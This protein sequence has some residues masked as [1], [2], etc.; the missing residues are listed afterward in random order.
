MEPIAY[1]DGVQSL[2]NQASQHARDPADPAWVQEILDKIRIGPDLTEDQKHRITDLIREYPDIFALSLSEVF[3][4][5]FASHK[6]KIHAD[7]VLPKKSYQ[8]LM[9][10][11]QR[12]F[13]NDII[14]DMETAGIIQAVPV[15]AIKCLNSTH[16]AP[17]DDGKNLGMT[18]A[19][20]LR[21]CNQQ[22]Q[23]NGLPDFWEQ[24]KWEEDADNADQELETKDEGPKPLPKKWQ[25]CQAFHTMNAATQ[26]PVFPSGDL[27]TKQQAVAGKR[28]ASVI[29]LAAGYYV[30]RMDKEAVPYTAF[31][32]EGRGFYVYLRMPFGLTGAPTMFCEMV[33][34]ALDGM[35]GNELVNWMDDICIADDEF[36]S[37]FAKM[38]KFF[39][40]CRERGLSLAPAKCKHFQLEVVFGRVTISA[41]GITLNDNKIAAVID[42]PE[43]QM[44]HELLG[45]LGL[46]GFFRCHI[47]GYVTIAQ[48]LSDLIRDVKGEKLKAGGKIRKDAYKRA[49]QAKSINKSWG[50]EQKKAFLTLKVAVTSAPVLKTLQYDGRI[51]RVVMDGS[52]KG[53]GGVLLQ[54]FETED[55]TGKWTKAWHP[56]AFCSKQTS[57]SEEQYEPFLLEFA[58]LKFV[59]DEF[60]HLTYGSQIEIET[61]CQALRDVL[62][63]KRQ[64]VTHTRWEES[65]TCRNIVDIWHWPGVSNI[66]ADAISWKWSEARGPSTGKDST[67]W[68]V[69]PNWEAHKGIVNDIMHIGE[70]EVH[71][72][73]WEHFKD[74]LWL[75]EVVEV[76]TEGEL[77]D[78]CPQ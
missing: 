10:E 16:L 19:A 1:M 48:P 39:G 61:D 42:W 31:H 76:L 59:L 30:I 46:T 38:C 24:I 49:L 56:I 43:P 18:R 51:F 57:V 63:N 64:S 20:L 12:K 21:R 14:D 54:E 44:S 73:I 27:K 5:D 36:E 45:F 2:A 3:P 17:K 47:K 53:F 29:D 78:I 33:A 60:D 23:A 35:I 65:I 25:V 41:A 58:A 62:L 7:V 32:V 75:S 70:A 34:T 6:L 28:W 8:R 15:D 4:V 50:E 68:M 66:I 72:E 67:D 22:C 52:K 74:D 71:A 9:M 37:K 11:P 13:F 40:K 26:V 69:Q 55:P 77:G